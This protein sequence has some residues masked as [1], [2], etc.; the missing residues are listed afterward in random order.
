MANAD[1]FRVDLSAVDRDRL[2]SLSLNDVILGMSRAIGSGYI[3]PIYS[4]CMMKAALEL[5]KENHTNFVLEDWETYYKQCLDKRSSEIK[6]KKA[7]S[8]RFV[9]IILGAGALAAGFAFGYYVL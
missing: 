5:Y 4:E 1:V 9:P 6:S 7:S 8:E 3:A 2:N